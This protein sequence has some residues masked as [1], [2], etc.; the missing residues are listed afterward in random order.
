MDGVRQLAD[1]SS[2]F[3]ARTFLVFCL[4]DFGLFAVEFNVVE[5]SFES[6]IALQ[7]ET[8][9]FCAIQFG[10]SQFSLFAKHIIGINYTATIVYF[11][12]SSNI[13]NAIAINNLFFNAKN[14]VLLVPI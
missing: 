4:F 13:T 6:Q 5:I 8:F 2:I 14:G 10:V 7:A 9:L 1:I 11:A 3:Y 12:E